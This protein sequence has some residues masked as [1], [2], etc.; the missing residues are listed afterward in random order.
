MNKTKHINVGD[1]RKKL[2]AVTHCYTRQTDK[3]F[4]ID[5]VCDCG[6][7]TTIHSSS[8]GRNLACGKCSSSRRGPK[9]KSRSLN[10]LLDNMQDSLTKIKFLIETHKL[11]DVD[12]K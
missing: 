9:P 12:D 10:D 5:V 6:E 4:V 3:K 8:F 1:K 7:R 11:G 2:T